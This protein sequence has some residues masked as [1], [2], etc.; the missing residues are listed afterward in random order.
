MV[1]KQAVEQY[2]NEV[3]NQKYPD[4]EHSV[5]MKREELKKLREML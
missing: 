2:R 5:A 3:I 4:S 1:I